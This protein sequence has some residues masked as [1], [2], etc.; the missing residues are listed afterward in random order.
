MIIPYSGIVILAGV[1]SMPFGAGWKGALLAGMGGVELTLAIKSLN[2]FQ[3]EK[4]STPYTAACTG[5]PH[6]PLT[7]LQLSLSSGNK[8]LS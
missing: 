6:S 7:S 2:S 1:V 8:L 4:K 3:A 5:V